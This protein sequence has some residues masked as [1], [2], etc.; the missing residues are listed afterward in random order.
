MILSRERHFRGLAVLAANGGGEMSE[1]GLELKAPCE[2]PPH[3]VATAAAPVAT[4][5]RSQTDFAR[6]PQRNLFNS[7]PPEAVD[8]PPPAQ[9]ED[10]AEGAFDGD[11]VVFSDEAER[12]YQQQGL[13]AFAQSETEA[14][15]RPLTGGPFRPVLE[16][17]HDIQSAYPIENTSILTLI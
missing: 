16:A 11:A 7:V 14:A 5:S 9:G 2:I 15:S 4:R 6:I 8:T 12:V 13:D 10:D 17:L 1:I 3:T